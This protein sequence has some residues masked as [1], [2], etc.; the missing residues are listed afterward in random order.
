MKS[1][2]LITQLPVNNRF[3]TILVHVFCISISA[4]F[5]SESL[6]GTIDSGNRVVNGKDADYSQHPW[7]VYLQIDKPDNTKGRV[8]I[9]GG[10]IINA[11]RGELISQKDQMMKY[12][13]QSESLDAPIR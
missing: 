2:H 11:S 5:A 7:A 12:F 3:S 1:C 8:S 13:Q 6:W 10:T 4:I 9:C